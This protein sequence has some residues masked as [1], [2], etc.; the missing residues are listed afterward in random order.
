M[1]LVALSSVKAVSKVVGTVTDIENKPK[2]L[3]KAAKN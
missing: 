2:N 1:G 3:E